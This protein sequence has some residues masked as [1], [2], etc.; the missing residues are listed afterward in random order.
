MRQ[1]SNP[2]AL[3]VYIHQSI[4]QER[5]E[6]GEAGIHQ[7]LDAGKKF[8]LAQTLREGGSI[9]FPHAGLR[10]SGHQIAAAVHACLDS[11]A[12]CVLAVGVLHALTPELQDARVRVAN[13]AEVTQEKYWGIQGPRRKGHKNWEEE[14]S[15]LDFQF[16]WHVECQRRGIQGPEL[17]VRY[18][19]LTGGKPDILPGIDELKEIAKNAVVVSTADMFHHGIGYGDPPEA[20]LHPEQGGS[21]WQES[22]LK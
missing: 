19:Y 3:K 5:A 14:F 18:P 22:A 21:D 2:Q 9:I 4:A 13:G 20:A 7:I 10:A 17:I 8:M 12:N 15:L 1:P 11:G 16:L 6:L